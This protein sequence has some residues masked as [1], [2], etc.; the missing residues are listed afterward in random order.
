[1]PT[2]LRHSERSLGS[3]SLIWPIDEAAAIFNTT[4]SN[5]IGIFLSPVLILGYIGASGDVPIGVTF[6]ELSIRVILPIFVGQFLRHMSKT[7]V[8]FVTKYKT[9]FSQAQ[10]HI[11]VFIIYTTFCKTFS[12]E[13]ESNI[14]DIFWM[15]LFQF[16]LLGTFMIL[17]WI[18]LRLL[19]HDEPQLRVMGLFGCTHKTLA[20]GVPLINA[21][22]EGNP[23][24]GLYTLPLLIWQPMQ[25]VIG[26]A[27]SPRLKAFVE[28]EKERLG[29]VD[30]EGGKEGGEEAKEEGG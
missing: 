29:I 6:Y 5:M 8:D 22:Y 27:L 7:V 26:T 21:I 30:E 14:G 15:I 3:H 20:V 23:N 28:T 17:S 4:F 24:V 12:E 18:L 1:V 10:Q 2:T 9:F 13:R 11:L 16:F 19:F 25:L